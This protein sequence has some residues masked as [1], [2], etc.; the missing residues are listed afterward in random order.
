MERGVNL[1]NWLV[2]EKWMSPELFADTTAEDEVHLWEQ[3]DDDAARE[4]F[5]THRDS[6][7][8]DRDFAYLAARGIDFVRLPVPYFVFGD[9]PERIGCIDYV[10]SA[11]KWADRYGVRI[12]L[13]LHTVPD[14]QNGF[15]NGGLCG[16]CKF[17]Q[18]P[19]HVDLALD[20]L[21]RLA[22]R[23]GTRDSLWGIEVLNEPVSPELWHSL[24]VP[25]RYPAVDPEHAAGSEGVPTT[26]L[27]DFYGRAYDRI[28]SEAPETSVVFHDGFR[29]EEWVDVLTAPE[30]ENIMVDSHLYVM[31]ASIGGEKTADEYVTHVED[32]F[33]DQVRRMSSHFPILVGEWNLDTKAPSFVAMDDAERRSFHQRLA[34]AHFRAFEAATAWCY[35]SYKLHVDDRAFDAWDLLK[36]VELGLVPSRL[37]REI[38][39]TTP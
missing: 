21:G 25:R 39:G 2:L 17:H 31:M 16:V 4:R 19:E 11:F 1:G 38:S 6:Y 32:V 33:G 20:V 23:Y 26:F 22:E 28:R 5:R 24:D 30:F 35:W 3:L 37:G 9:V 12:L 29:V 13:D 34:T 10:D 27:V 15:D 8:T 18:N 7:V 36:A 14:S